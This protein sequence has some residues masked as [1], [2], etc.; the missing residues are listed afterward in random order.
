[1]YRSEQAQFRADLQ[2]EGE[3]RELWERLEKSLGT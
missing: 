2:R 1:M 3:W